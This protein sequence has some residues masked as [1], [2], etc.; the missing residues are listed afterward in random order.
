MSLPRHTPIAT[1]WDLLVELARAENC[2]LYVSGKILHFHPV[3]PAPVVVTRI[4]DCR[5]LISL[6]ID[7]TLP[8]TASTSLSVESWNSRTQST[9][10]LNQQVGGSEAGSDAPQIRF[11]Q[12]NLNEPDAIHLLAR[13]NREISQSRIGVT[14]TQPGD[15]ALLPRDYI[16]LTETY[17]M[18][19]IYQISTIERNYHPRRGFVQSVTA[20]SPT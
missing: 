18:D 5:K 2:H 20:R 13:H 19:G 8:L 4:I 10:R 9:V 7:R 3:L 17:G 15:L 1:D 12:P 14:F 16:H 6:R 11:L